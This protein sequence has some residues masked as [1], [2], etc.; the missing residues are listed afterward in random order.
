MTRLG[1]AA[2]AGG[3]VEVDLEA[4]ADHADGVVDA[5]LIVEDEL[6]R[7]EVQDFAVGR[8][9]DGAGAVDGCADLL[10]G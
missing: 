1:D 8:E 5:G 9:G 4:V 7:E 10:R 3:E 6:L 2:G